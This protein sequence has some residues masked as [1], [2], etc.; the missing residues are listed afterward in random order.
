MSKEVMI[1]RTILATWARH[2]TVDPHLEFEICL[3]KDGIRSPR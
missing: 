2:S 1:A 3:G